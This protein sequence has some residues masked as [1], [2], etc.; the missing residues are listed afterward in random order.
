MISLSKWLRHYTPGTPFQLVSGTY[1]LL[2]PAVPAAQPALPTI[3]AINVDQGSPVSSMPAYL[4]FSATPV[5][6]T[7][8]QEGAVGAAVGPSLMRS[9]EDA[10]PPQRLCFGASSGHPPDYDVS[11]LLAQHDRALVRLREEHQSEIAA[12]AA[13]HKAAVQAQSNSHDM[14][15][16]D[17]RHK[18]TI[19]ENDLQSLR[20]ENAQLQKRAPRPQMPDMGLIMSLLR[21]V[22]RRTDISASRVHTVLTALI[23]RDRFAL[24][25]HDHELF[26][27]SVPLVVSIATM[28]G[29]APS[30]RKDLQRAFRA[31][32]VVRFD[33]LAPSDSTPALPA[34]VDAA[35][36]P[37]LAPVASAPSAAATPASSDPPSP[38]STDPLPKFLQWLNA[39]P[40]GQE[41]ESARAFHLYMNLT[42]YRQPGT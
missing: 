4:D 11:E 34:A 19:F 18:V 26:L 35:P 31:E 41:S 3:D 29:I 9:P 36:Q 32:R 28:L 17:L 16:R 37:A 42:C 33:A 12:Q 24:L 15:L 39:I 2:S 20:A 30:D 8:T 38:A 25:A 21:D 1:S 7:C 5:D 13:H 14:A 6:L 27:P 23:P 40:A 10:L 22:L